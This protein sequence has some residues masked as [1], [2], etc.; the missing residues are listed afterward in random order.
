MSD[1]GFYWIQKTAD[2]IIQYIRFSLINGT[3]P[4]FWLTHLHSV[5]GV[6]GWTPNGKS[7]FNVIFINELYLASQTSELIQSLN[8]SAQKC[9]W[10][11]HEYLRVFPEL[12]SKP[13]M[14]FYSRKYYFR[15]QR[16]VHLPIPI[17]WMNGIIANFKNK[18]ATSV[19]CVW[20]VWRVHTAEVHDI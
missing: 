8:V 20:L 19:W 1:V 4:K 12:S 9:V 15:C 17:K 2:S 10:I 18:Y 3:P 7:Y 6:D 16:F 5:N 14:K 11:W 13:D